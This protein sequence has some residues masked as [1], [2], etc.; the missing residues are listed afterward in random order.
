MNPSLW[1]KSE[2]HLRGP[3][4]GWGAGWEPLS[5]CVFS[6]AAIP[7]GENDLQKHRGMPLLRRGFWGVGSPLELAKLPF[8]GEPRSW[9][10]FQS[11]GIRTQAHPEPVGRAARI[12][13]CLH[14]LAGAP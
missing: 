3:D 7:Q 12:R 5:F 4:S 8:L 9:G 10:P 1:R 11:P 14:L 2:G 13:Y 6:E